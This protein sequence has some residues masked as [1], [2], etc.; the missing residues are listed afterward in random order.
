MIKVG[1]TLEIAWWLDGRETTHQINQ[2]KDV[3]FP[4]EIKNIENEYGILF[5]P[6][7]YT[8]KLPGED[9]VPQVPNHIHGPDV[10]MLVCESMAIANKPKKLT[11]SSE[12]TGFTLDLP[13]DQLQRLRV[14]T[15]RAYFRF[16]G[17]HISNKNCDQI[18]EA[19][20]PDVAMRTL[21]AETAAN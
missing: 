19:L 1:D 4:A 9:R 14:I 18:I 7:N 21:R 20:G 3:D 6:P 16:H 13:K 10:R 2:M 11:Q 17:V 15:R 12:L 8:I 5:A